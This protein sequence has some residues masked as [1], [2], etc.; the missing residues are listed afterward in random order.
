MN[1]A[2]QPSARPQPFTR[3]R[4]SPLRLENRTR[5]TIVAHEVRLAVTPWARG[6]GL[7]GHPGLAPGQALILQPESSIHMFFMRCPLDVLFLGPD[8]Q[9]LFLYAGLRPWRISRI[10]R[11]SQRVVE[12]PVGSLAASATQQGDQVVLRPPAS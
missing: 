8:D 12:L 5:G 6:L 7:M 3:G 9:V 1:P 4:P 10:V 2:A 11:G